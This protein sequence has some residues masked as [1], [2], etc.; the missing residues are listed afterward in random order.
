MWCELLKNIS[1]DCQFSPPASDEDLAEIEQALKLPFPEDLASLLKESNGVLGEYGL[2]L[3]WACDRIKSDNHMFRSNPDF[4][5]LY[6]PFDGL[7]FFGD[8]GN[9]DQFA[10]SVCDGE[11]RRPDIFVWDHETDGRTWIAPS[12]KRYLQGWLTGEIKV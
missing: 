9:G 6:M 10:Y 12:L 5:Q 7:F 2:G 1:K 4:K 11:V 3:V 8:A